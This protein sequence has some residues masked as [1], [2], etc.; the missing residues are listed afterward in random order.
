ML[1]T[2]LFSVLTGVLSSESLSPDDEKKTLHFTKDLVIHNDVL[3]S[4]FITDIVVGD[5]GEIVVAMNDLAQVRVFG[6]DGELLQAFGQ[7]GRGPG[8]FQNLMSVS[9]Q[10]GLIHALDSGAN[11]KLNVFNPAD[12]EATSTVGLPPLR[13]ETGINIAID[14]MLISEEKVLVTYLPTTSN[15][16]IGTELTS[17]FYLVDT[18]LNDGKT[19]IF[20]SPARERYVTRTE[21]GF[22][23]TA[24]PFGRTNHVTR[25]GDRVFHMWTGSAE[26]QIY[27]IESWN[28]IGFITVDE[29]AEP[30]ALQ[31]EDYNRYYRERLGIESDDSMSELRARAANDMGLQ[32]SL[33]SV[34]S[35]ID[36]RD[37]LHDTFPV[38]DGMFSC[39]NYLWITAPHFDRNMQHII[40]IDDEGY[41][42][43][44]GTLSSGVR[45]RH[46]KNGYLYGTDKDDDGFGTVVR[47]KIDLR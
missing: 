19:L 41:V 33:I 2:I 22:F 32:M 11:P 20:K 31:E 21:S 24:M 9:L 14:K 44:T 40:Q 5:Q 46:I 42:L 8:D 6:P 34:T 38:Y 25:L 45:V 43:A 18:S 17:S 1:F 37:K 3:I 12:V 13:T 29:L 15:D 7:R 16:N 23:N 30:I 35:M 28:N 26:I 4:D 27:D 36:N 10:S 39:G 47:F